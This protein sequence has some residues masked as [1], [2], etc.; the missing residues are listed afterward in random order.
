MKSDVENDN[1][2]KEKKK[3][4]S[5]YKVIS[6]ESCRKIVK[7]MKCQFQDPK[8]QAKFEQP[9]KP[10]LSKVEKPQMEIVWGN[11]ILWNA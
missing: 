6:C 1:D 7:F 11:D 9:P 5:V 8:K 3:T 4:V 2:L 10:K